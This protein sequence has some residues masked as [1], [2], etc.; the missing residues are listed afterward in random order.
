MP[1]H[2]EAIPGGT[3]HRYRSS[4]RFSARSRTRTA[5][6]SHTL[7]RKKRIGAPASAPYYAAMD[8]TD[9]L[10]NFLHQARNAL[11]DITRSSPRLQ[12]ATQQEVA[13]LR[14]DVERLERTVR[15]L[16]ERIRAIEAAADDS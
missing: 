3:G 7:V 13:A 9:P 14:A 10:S 8:S 6:F 12:F 11:E 5:Q 1:G 4:H 2:I 15:A 16:E